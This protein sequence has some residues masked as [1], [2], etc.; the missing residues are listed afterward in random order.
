MR[1]ARGHQ[2][3]AAPGEEILGE[4]RAVGLAQLELALAHGQDRAPGAEM[5]AVVAARDLRSQQQAETLRRLGGVV[6][7]NLHAIAAVEHGPTIPQ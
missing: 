7:G 2:A 1:V 3:L 4:P 5:A 6:D